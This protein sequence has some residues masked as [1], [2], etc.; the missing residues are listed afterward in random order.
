MSEPRKQSR[1]QLLLF[2]LDSEAMAVPIEYVWRVE[3]LAELAIT[4]VPRGPAF[5]DGVVNVRGTVLPVVDLRK[6]FGLP[7]AARPPRARLL[8]VETERQRVGLIAYAVT[9]ITSYPASAVEPPPPLVG[10]V[11]GEFVAGVVQDGDNL[12]LVVDLRETLTPAERQELGT[13]PRPEGVQAAASGLQATDATA[14][15]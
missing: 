5:L 10:H 15:A 3:P 9:G 13:I 1:V 2:R 14:G 4:R 8:V 7:P 6:R 11:S 12:I